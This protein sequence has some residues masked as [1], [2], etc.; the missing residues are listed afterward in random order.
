MKSP[1]F[2][3]GT[4]RSGTTLLCRM[5]TAHKD[6]FIKNE[7]PMSQIFRP[8]YSKEQIVTEIDKAVKNRHG[9]S[10]AELLKSE[11]KSIWG[12][13]D[14]QLTEHIEALKQFL[15]DAR[16]IIIIRDP[17][18]VVRSYIENAWGLGTNCYSGSLRWRE[19]VEAQ[20]KF[21][22]EFPEQVVTLKYEELVSNQKASLE[23][24]CEFL[25]VP[26]DEGMMNYSDKKAFVQMNRQ[27][28]N[29]FK[30]PDKAIIDKWKQGLSS[31]QIKVINTECSELIKTLEYQ[32]GD[33]YEESVPNGLKLYYKLHQKIIGEIQ[34]QY[35][36]RI[37]GYKHRYA[38]WKARKRVDA[39]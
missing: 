20:L 38:Q 10:I 5:L 15:P 8:G 23:K 27:S 37:G 32:T 24:L 31:H 22:A 34:I 21:A 16:F 36:W 28:V 7:G 14:P 9:Q 30:A 4:Q 18:A 19:E 12:F 25:K 6:I 1:V 13:K 11:G 35:R 2:L 33:S 3:V 26:F 29:T 39:V 17:R